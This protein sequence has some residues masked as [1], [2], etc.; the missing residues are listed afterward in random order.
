MPSKNTSVPRDDR[1]EEYIDS[2]LMTHRLRHGQRVSVRIYGIYGVY[3]THLL[4]GQ[5]VDGDCTCPSGEWPCKHLRALRA[6]W[7]LNPG[8]FL[9][10]DG[11]FADLNTQPKSTLIAAITQ[12][13]MAWPETLGV[14]EVE[15]F[16]P[17]QD[18][19]NPEDSIDLDAQDCG[20]A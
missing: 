18:V 9:D 5:D 2:A 3:R 8:S 13:V 17:L 19:V 15:G 16:E 1:A 12:I 6:T 11:W 4:L 10:L 20:A 7:R 14:L